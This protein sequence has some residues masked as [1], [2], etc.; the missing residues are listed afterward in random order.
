MAVLISTNVKGQTQE[1]YDGVLTAVRDSIKQAP[2]FIM[3]C[4]HPGEGE[5][6]VYE[7]WNSKEEADQWFGKV[8]VPN[9]PPGIHPKRAYTSLHSIVTPFE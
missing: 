1:G 3:H 9:L 4:A 7:V 5:W 8:V 2:G 6:K